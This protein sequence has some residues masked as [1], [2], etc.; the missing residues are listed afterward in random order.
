MIL[1]VIGTIARLTLA[2]SLAIIAAYVGVGNIEPLDKTYAAVMILFSALFLILDG[3]NSVFS[4][5]GR[6][7]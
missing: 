1:A 4:F 3:I 5:S 2:C 7:K 6:N